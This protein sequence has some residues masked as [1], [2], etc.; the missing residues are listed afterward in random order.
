MRPVLSLR[1]AFVTAKRSDRFGLA[2][3]RAAKAKPNKR[4]L[5][6]NP[7]QM[8]SGSFFV[9]A[10]PGLPTMQVKLCLGALYCEFALT[11]G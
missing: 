10:C 6:E 2:T 3:W 8:A 9:R 1:S 4:Y 11:D 7:R 5:G